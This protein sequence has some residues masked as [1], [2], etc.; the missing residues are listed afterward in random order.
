VCKLIK[1]LYGLKQAH[2]QWHEN[3]YKVMLSNDFLISKGDKCL[4]V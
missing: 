1:S 2:I 3:F 4:Y